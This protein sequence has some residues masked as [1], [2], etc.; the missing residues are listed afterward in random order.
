[1]GQ[2]K[3]KS[4][5]Q[6]V[7]WMHFSLGKEIP[8]QLFKLSFLGK[9]IRCPISHPH[10]NLAFYLSFFETLSCKWKLI[11]IVMRWVTFKHFLYLPCPAKSLTTSTN[12]V[13]SVPMCPASMK[14]YIVMNYLWDVNGLKTPATINI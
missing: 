3:E 2:I 1:M 11:D 14:L 9:Q 6:K 12:K 4:L 13:D 8:P 7:A 5:T 10:L